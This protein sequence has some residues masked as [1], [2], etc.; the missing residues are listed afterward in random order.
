MAFLLFWH[1]ILYAFT[2]AAGSLNYLTD[3]D[4]GT[5]QLQSYVQT[6]EYLHRRIS[7]FLEFPKNVEAK[8]SHEEPLYASIRVD[9]GVVEKLATSA[10]KRHQNR[11]EPIRPRS[12]HGRILIS[13]FFDIF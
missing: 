4:R 3:R 13:E 12:I 10:F 1:L 6:D 2:F 8:Y 7:L 11:R 9:F 5:V